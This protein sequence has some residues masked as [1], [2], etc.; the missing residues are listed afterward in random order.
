MPDSPPD[1]PTSPPHDI[2]PL[3]MSPDEFRRLGHQ[4][5]DRT[6]DALAHIADY[7]VYQRVPPPTRDQLLALPLPD[8][9][10]APEELL[11]FFRDRIQPYPL[12]NGHPRFFGWV[13]S[14]PSH[15]GV[16]AALLEAAFN[17]SAAGGD[18]AAIYL[19]RAVTRWLMQLTGFPLAGSPE[20]GGS[21]ETT[22]SFGL[23]VSGTSMATLTALAAAR[24]RA[25]KRLGV[26]IRKTGL[27]KNPRLTLY[28]TSE[29]HSCVTKSVEMLG[30]GSD[31]IR[32][33]PT[34]SAHRMDVAALRQ[35]IAAD[36]TAGLSPFCV[37]ANAGTVST[38]AIDPLDAIADVCAEHDL[39]L[40]VDGAYGVVGILDPSKRDLYRGL[41]RTDSL[42]LDP[43]KWLSVPIEC[44]CVLVRDQQNLRDTFSIAPPYLRTD[45]GKGVGGLPW[46]SEYGFQQTRGFRALR[47][48][49]TI[50]SAG[51]DGLAESITRHNTLA[52][53]LADQISAAPDLELSA[54]VTLSIV[55]FRY[56]PPGSQ[57]SPDQL[58]AL[59]KSIMEAVQISGDA[60]LT[61]TVVNGRFVLRACI[62]HYA[63]MQSDVAALLAAVR[64]AAATLA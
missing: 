49:A 37:V 26:D 2:S 46:Y 40:H 60:F 34:D 44:G 36:L 16:L 59:N 54:P 13:N 62:L 4:L 53:W 56:I 45:P 29:A 7:P 10:I 8:H 61:S 1:S 20:P 24:F 64:K 5:I 63:T 15:A 17:T 31:A 41:D 48:W 33:V 21:S 9:G 57:H 30:L 28:A 55:C 39:W 35:L 47:C 19:E 23:L 25:T 12:G 58:D 22:D 50:A 27:P 32:K 51:R 11:A 52:L 3:A 18:Q 14:P 38:G 6:A 42:A 43:H